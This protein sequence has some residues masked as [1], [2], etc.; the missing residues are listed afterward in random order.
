VVVGGGLGGLAVAARLAKLGHDVTLLE[1]T[2]RVGGALAPVE[3]DGFVWD[4]GAPSTLLPAVVRDLFRKTGRPLERELD[5]V[6]LEPLREHRFADGS[7]LALPG[8]SRA[9]QITAFDTL[10][11]GL[12]RAWA[13]YV[14]A[15]AEPWDLLRR[16]YAEHP[17]DR[18]TTDPAATAL[19]R[20]RST[21]ARAAASLPDERLRAVAEHHARAGGHD[22]A[23]VPAWL[24]V[25]S[26]LEQRL[27]GATVPGGFSRLAAVLGD[28]L[29]IRGVE[30]RLSTPVRDLS[31]TG[32]RVRG[33][34]TPTGDVPADL[35]VL[36]ADPARLPALARQTRRTAPV[37]PPTVVHLGVCGDPEWAFETVVHG[38]PDLLLHRG[39]SAPAGHSALT[40][41]AHH[42]PADADPVALLAA[43]GTDLR[44]RIVS[45]VDRSPAELAAHG[46][47]YGLA[48]SGPATVRRRLGPRTPL[49]GL[50]AAGAHAA[51]G[52]GV[53]FVGLSAALVAQVVGPA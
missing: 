19:L 51:P 5:L 29:A 10:G 3:R 25:W 26:Y 13:A 52:P 47:P 2:D 31:V 34:R 17:Y 32:R 41:V 36:A 12:G 50:L 23:R 35:V 9:A 15:Y 30:V 42:L 4:G 40:I 27:G 49:D 11:A 8:G 6:P 18:A 28:R 21:L 39:G 16:G 24:G 44:D 43:R 53:P 46:S 48:W 7:V 14:A 45:R 22:P 37:P 33:V 20:D 38:R 1:A